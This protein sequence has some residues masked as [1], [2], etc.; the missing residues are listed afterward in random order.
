MKMIGF[1]VTGYEGA[2]LIGGQKFS[3]R[4]PE[5]VYTKG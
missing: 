4:E 1:K 3:T 2:L 5:S